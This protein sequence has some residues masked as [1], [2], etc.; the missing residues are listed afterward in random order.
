[1]RLAAERDRHKLRNPSP[2]DH[3]DTSLLELVEQA[4]EQAPT[5]S[6]WNVESDP[7]P[8]D[9]WIR[10][11]SF[12][13][14]TPDQ[15][16]KLHVSSIAD[17]AEELLRRALPVLLDAGAGFKVAKSLHVLN[18]LNAGEGGLGQVGKFVTVYPDDDDQAVALAV[19]LDEA[20]KGLPG[21]EVPTDRAIRP[22]SLV[23]YRYGAFA[24]KLI[25]TATGHIVPAIATPDGEL[26]PDRGPGL[27]AGPEWA[28][29]PFAAAGLG[30]EQT[31]QTVGNRYLVTAMLHKSA[32]GA[33]YA[34]LDLEAGRTCVLKH[35]RRFGRAGPD[36]R[37]ARDYL[38]QEADVLARLA[39]DK[40][41][42]EL[43]ELIEQD[44]D[45]FLAMEEI[46]GPTLSAIVSEEAAAGHLAPEGQVLEWGRLLADALALVHERGLVYRDLKASNIIVSPDGSLRLLDFEL[47]YVPEG[48]DYLHGIGTR[49]YASPQ[50]AEGERA[51]T[52]DDVYSLG[53]VLYY[54]ATGAEPAASPDDMNLLSR[55]VTRLNPGIGPR[56]ES[57]IERCLAPERADRWPSM[58][59]LYDELGSINPSAPGATGTPAART[60]EAD[61][62]AG[63]A[64]RVA[65]T[66]TN[67]ALPVGDGLVTWVSGDPSLAGMGQRDL[68][69][70]SGGVVLALAELVDEFQDES[71][72]DILAAGARAL[73]DAPM[74]DGVRLP[75]FYVG[76]A[77]VAAC[78]LRAGQVLG[79][80]SLRRLALERA[81]AVA[82]L[83]YSSPDLFNGT[84]GRLRAHLLMW[85]D[86]SDADQLKAAVAAGDELLDSARA[87]GPELSWTIPPGFDDLSGRSYLGYAHGVAG[88]GDVMI[89][90]FEATAQD[91]FADAA[92]RAGTRLQRLAL[93][94]LDDGSGLVWPE[95]EGGAPSGATWCHGSTGIARFFL[96][97]ATADL[98]A[99][100]M[101]V[102]RRAAR[103]V[104]LGA[105][106]ADPSACHGLAGN[107]E[108]LLDMAQA[109]EDAAY[110]SQA[111]NLAELLEAFAVE[112]DDGELAWYSDVPPTVTPDYTVGYSGIAMCLLRLADPLRRPHLLSRK[113]FAFRAHSTAVA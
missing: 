98:D 70:G 67:A 106:G 39:G 16:W 100:A 64:R 71:H 36:G 7:D 110:V 73:A 75:G 20:T 112:S 24:E 60:I 78:L 69:I 74:L 8:S 52:A 41:F 111:A 87:G 47:A 2:T 31:L 3:T 76:E 57:A 68:C 49:G 90:L 107:I 72:R 17:S 26:V 82:A 55:P 10:V 12:S 48:S 77:G 4:V 53:A 30:V 14:R 38:R 109:T 59:A 23:H 62:Y 85:D 93:P 56:L 88:I 9:V 104:A 89:D 37:D 97:L 91:R 61:R 94:S 63:M 80:E 79:D 40:R 81:R 83:P 22:G 44:D 50:Q 27:A 96:H 21:P 32:G 29:D 51:T 6:S 95:S 66:L 25:Q 86:S 92:V 99:N 11:H 28:G 84:A 35:A 34:A 108:L 42:P 43:Y 5:S 33:V 105:R 54:I 113:G 1:V 46:E 15:G 101:D 18:A 65:G 45:L 58:H 19:A 103:M 102:A 13:A